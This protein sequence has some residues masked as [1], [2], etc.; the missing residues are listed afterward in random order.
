MK[1]KIIAKPAWW[2]M[3]Y[4]RTLV[5]FSFITGLEIDHDKLQRKIQ[6]GIRARMEPVK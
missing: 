1:V 6:K 2:L 3:P 5:L 4:I